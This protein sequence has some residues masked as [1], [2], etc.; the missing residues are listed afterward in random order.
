MGARQG[1]GQVAV[2][3]VGDDDRRPG[4]GDQEIRAG[5]PDVGGEEFGPEH[6]ARLAEQLLRLAEVAPGRQRPVRLAEVLLDVAGGDVDRRG[7]DVRGRLAA[8]LDDVFAEVGLD[9]LHP[10]RLDRLVEPD[11]LRDHRLALG[12]ALRAE[13]LAEV[14]DDPA[15]RFGVLGVVHMAAALGDLAL[16]GLEIEVEMRERVVLDGAGAVAQRLELRQPVGRRGA[17]AGEVARK[18][19]RPLQARVGQR[20]VDVLLEPGRGGDGG[21]RSASF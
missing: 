16:V 20:L 19:H 17:P 2:A 9:R 1:L 8:K 5:D 3:L 12:D 7:D 6:G 4:L 21:H 18:G 14:D 11:L 10:R 15:R 13:P